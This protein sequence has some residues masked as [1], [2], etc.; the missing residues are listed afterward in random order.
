MRRGRGVLWEA[1]KRSASWLSLCGR[2]LGWQ[3]ACAGIGGIGDTGNELVL[4]PVFV[5]HGRTCLAACLV[6]LARCMHRRLGATCT[7]DWCPDD[8]I[9]S[10]LIYR[11]GSPC[12]GAACPLR[13]TKPSCSTDKLK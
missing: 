5:I 6:W 2:C 13:R 12:K 4:V 11:A 9:H 7:G 10:K 8:T 1:D 3:A